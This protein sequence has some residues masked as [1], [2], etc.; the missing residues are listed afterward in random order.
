MYAPERSGM[1]ESETLLTHGHP[2]DCHCGCGPMRP[3]W[4]LWYEMPDGTRHVWTGD[5]FDPDLDKALC[6]ET[7]AESNAVANSRA[8]MEAYSAH[9]WNLF[10]DDEPPDRGKFLDEYMHTM[11]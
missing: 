6:F 9:H 10:P 2:P 5:H 7:Q 4:L 11:M 1:S 3:I 8:Y